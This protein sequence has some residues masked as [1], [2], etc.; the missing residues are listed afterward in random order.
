MCK[1]ISPKA[2]AFNNS[3]N[4]LQKR[5]Q[6]FTLKKVMLSVR[7]NLNPNKFIH[8]ALRIHIDSDSGKCENCCKLSV[9]TNMIFPFLVKCLIN[10]NKFTLAQT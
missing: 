2:N 10:P 7:I 3:E 6:S 9:N 1:Y 4:E 5:F 8:I